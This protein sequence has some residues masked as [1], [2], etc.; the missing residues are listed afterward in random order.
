MTAYVLS[1]RDIN[2][3]MLAEAGG[4]GV[5]LGELWHLDG[6][7]VPDGFCVVTTAY[8]IAVAD[9]TRLQELLARLPVLADGESERI[10]DLSAQIRDLIEQVEIPQDVRDQVLQTLAE[11]GEDDNYAVRSSATAEDLPG[12]S[13]AGQHDTYLNISGAAEI[14]RHIVKCW[15]SLFS[16]RAVTYRIRNGLDHQTVAPAVIIQ[17]MVAVEASGI[18]FTADPMT[19]CRKTLS[20]EAGFGLGEALVSGLVEPDIYKVRNGKIVEKRIGHKNL[21]ILPLPNGGT[22]RKEVETTKQRSET[23]SDEQI[24]KLAAIGKRIEAHFGYP[25]DIEWCCSDGNTP[26]IYIVQSRPITTLFPIPEAKDPAKPR[27]FMSVGH[28]QMMTD[29]IKPLGISFFGPLAQ[30]SLDQAGGRVFADITHDLSS[31]MGRK[32]LVMASGKQDPLIQGAVK[33]LMEDKAFMASLPR[34]KRNLQGGVFTASSI[35]A[36][37]RISR[38]NDPSI[39]PEMLAEFDKEITAID[40]ELAG[41]SGEQVFD[42]I[43]KDLQ[44]LMTMAYD[45]RM[46]GAIIAALLAND[47]INKNV[48]KWLGE[49]SVAD[50]LAKSVDHNVTTEM[51][52]ALCGLADIVRKHPEVLE[53]LSGEPTDEN[54]FEEL[55]KLPGGDETGESFKVFLDK[56]GMRCPGEI[57]ISRPRWEEK[58]T[59]LIP[60]LLNNVRVLNPGEHAARFQ[61]GRLEAKAKEEEI[62]QRL[63]K[64]PGGRKKAQKMRHRIGVLRN[65][66]GC[67]E[68]PKYYIVRRYQVYK[69]ALLK[70]ADRLV[71]RGVL[72]DREDIFYLYYEELLSAVRTKNLD[73]SIIEARKADYRFYEK[74]TPPRVITSDGFV[75]SGESSPRDLPTGA[76]AGIAVSGGVAEGRARVVSAVDEA[77]LEEGDI[78]VTKFTDPSWTP[79][80]VTIK[81]LVTEVGGFTTHGAVI[82]R[83]YGLPAVVGVESATKL[84]RDG[85]KIRVNGTGGYVELL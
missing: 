41:L 48:E 18:M 38:K 24:L 44:N 13:F 5:N 39:I 66:I 17:K 36:A 55:V 83:E 16:E 20:I 60:V 73:Y 33:K 56:Y 7:E 43:A 61:K 80:F 85:Q 71:E 47:S 84:I 15:A 54:F 19:S 2:K 1:L 27:A 59:Q 6:V 35:M 67:R 25:Q 10:T 3:E 77:R 50:I 45:P 40:Q 82:T 9:N 64:M 58:P 63:E 49:K 37:L 76:L 51:G 74:L 14:M 31:F 11:C 81:G 34:G 70:E 68:Y 65:F 46:L 69:K 72:K 26:R 32:R 53:Y 29:P 23:L 8:Q 21:K 28:T 22:T 75:P 30:F 4:K 12:A 62:T 57:D 42:F 78:L 79:L 52:F